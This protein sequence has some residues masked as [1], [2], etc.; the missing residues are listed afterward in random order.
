MSRTISAAQVSGECAGI[1]RARRRRGVHLFNRRQEQRID[2]ESLARVSVGLE[3]TR[4]PVEIILAIELQRVD[5]DAYHD[6]R[7]FVARP[8]DQPFM[9]RMQRAHRRYQPDRSA[10]FPGASQVPDVGD[11]L[12]APG[13][14]HSLS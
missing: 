7:T 8:L 1:D 13:A 2:A 5:E 9:P 3:S 11:A 12:H 10:D 14:G 6:A 4:I